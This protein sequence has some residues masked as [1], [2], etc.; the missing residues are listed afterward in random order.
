M[1]ATEQKEKSGSVAGQIGT[2]LGRCSELTNAVL[3]ER[4]THHTLL[5]DLLLARFDRRMH[6]SIGNHWQ[7]RF[8]RTR[9]GMMAMISIVFSANVVHNEGTAHPYILALKLPRR[10]VSSIRMCD[11]LSGPHRADQGAQE[12]GTH[13]INGWNEAKF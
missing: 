2:S 13:L 6:A 7:M 10:V 12:Y 8:Y 4:A 9:D 3:H 5:L 1:A 11:N